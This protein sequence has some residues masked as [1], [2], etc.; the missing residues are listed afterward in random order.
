MNLSQNED[1]ENSEIVSRRSNDWYFVHFPD[2]NK[3]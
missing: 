3:R 1:I 2:A